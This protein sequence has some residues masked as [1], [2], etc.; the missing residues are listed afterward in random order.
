VLCRLDLELDPVP[1]FL[2]WAGE[3]AAGPGWLVLRLLA[4]P[5]DRAA[6]LAAPAWL[7]AKTL[8][9]TADPALLGGPLERLVLEPWPP[10]DP[11][12]CSSLPRARDPGLLLHIVRRLQ[13]RGLHVLV[14]PPGLP[15]PA[16]PLP[17]PGVLGLGR[18]PGAPSLAYSWLPAA[19][20]VAALLQDLHSGGSLGTALRG[21]AWQ[22][23]NT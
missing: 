2:Y 8:H 1:D 18:L 22:Y 5:G 4:G 17:P 7:R 11:A 14:L 9:V 6:A 20:E 23:L 10:G 15:P 13:E 3:L 19:P 16:L 21:A 12:N